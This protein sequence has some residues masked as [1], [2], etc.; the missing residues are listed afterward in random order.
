MSFSPGQKEAGEEN[1]FI[2]KGCKAC[3]FIHLLESAQIVNDAFITVM[4]GQNR[5]GRKFLSL[6]LEGI[7]GKNRGE[8]ML[9]NDLILIFVLA[10]LS[11]GADVFLSLYFSSFFFLSGFVLIFSR[12]HMILVF[13]CCSFK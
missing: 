10:R 3:C 2:W 6:L 12:V 4:T 8:I 5:I 7:I 13:F 9:F 1:G 11:C